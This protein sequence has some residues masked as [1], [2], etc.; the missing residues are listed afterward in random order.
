MHLLND[1]TYRWRPPEPSAAQR[2]VSRASARS[3]FVEFVYGPPPGVRIVCE[4]QLEYRCVLC[5][6][7]RPDTAD[8]EEQLGPIPYRKPNGRNGHHYLDFRVTLTSGRRIGMAVKS[9]KAIRDRKFAEFTAELRAVSAAAVPTVIDE[10]CLVTEHNINPLDLHNAQIFHAARMADPADD[11][12][13]AECVARMSGAQ[14][15]TQLCRSAGL[16]RGGLAA[17]ARAIRAGRLEMCRRE[18]LAE[19]T[20]V[21]KGG[22]A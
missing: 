19:T 4:S 17:A 9:R 7:Y 20:L 18:R 6:A 2:Q 8:I 13:L 12:H 5:A 15:I 21:R 1:K 11:E 3:V 16:E 14:P 22:V 10:L